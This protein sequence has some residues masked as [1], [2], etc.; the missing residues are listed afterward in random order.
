[1]SELGCIWGAVEVG[2]IGQ[3][4]GQIGVVMRSNI[5]EMEPITLSGNIAPLEEIAIEILRQAAAL[6]KSAQPATIRSIRELL[7]SMNCYYSNLIEGHNTRPIDIDRALREDYSSDPTTRNLQKESVAHIEVQKLMEERL[8]TEPDLNITNSDFLCWLHHEF[9]RRLP[10]EFLIVKSSDADL[11]DKVIPGEFRER[12]VEVGKHI[13]PVHASLPNFLK[14]FNEVYSTENKNDLEK[15]LV[16]AAAHHRLAWIHPFLDGNGRVVRLFSDAYFY[17]ANIDGY[18]LWNLSRG[19]A[20]RKA[21]YFKFL[22]LADSPRQG[23][24]DVRG[25]LSQKGLFDFTE[26]F[27]QTILDQIQFMQRLLSL[28]DMVFRIKVYA[29]RQ[30]S[31]KLL[32]KDSGIILTEVYMR[33]EV[34]RGGISQI[35]GR[36]ERT[37]R[38][39]ISELVA[40]RLLV[41]DTPKGALRLGFPPELLSYYFPDLYPGNIV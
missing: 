34:S 15:I 9:Y 20:R 16:S 29:E 4:I 11:I 17:K 38:R 40:S 35:I 12:E 8:R 27:L 33:G 39:V 23:D 7:W 13:P 19:L 18:G 25:N 41:S 28:N 32:P 10:E 30:I 31:L 26:F 37:T 3:K 5:S 2:V 22:A 6:V 14:R 21:D 1:M 36:P 24:F